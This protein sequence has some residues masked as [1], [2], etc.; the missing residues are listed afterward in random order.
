MSSP[1]KPQFPAA[2]HSPCM[3]IHP[4]HFHF[5]RASISIAPRNTTTCLA[6]QTPQFLTGHSICLSH[7]LASRSV[8]ITVPH[9]LY[10]LPPSLPL[11]PSVCLSV[12]LYVCSSVSLH[13]RQS[14]CQYDCIMNVCLYVCETFVSLTS[15]SASS[16][17][18]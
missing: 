5:C 7:H 15:S 14:L 8:T 18:I 6:F 9:A 12:Y 10:L 2:S 17:S 1:R 4:L 11:C 16:S 3:P 13:E